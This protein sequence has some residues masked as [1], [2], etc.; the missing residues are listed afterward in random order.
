M[1][2]FALVA[3]AVALASGAKISTRD[4]RMTVGLDAGKTFSVT[5]ADGR[6]PVC[7]GDGVM[8]QN[9]KCVPKEAGFSD[10]DAQGACC[11]ANCNF[12]SQGLQ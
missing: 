10:V 3:T 12:F 11:G 9:A 1:L 4:K 7:E 2:R 8:V 5:C 6:S